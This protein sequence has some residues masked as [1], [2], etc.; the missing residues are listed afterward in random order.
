M[1]VEPVDLENIK[2]D[3]IA[4]VDNLRSLGSSNRRWL[5]VFVTTLVISSLAIGS[6]VLTDDEGFLLINAS[7]KINGSLNVTEN[8]TAGGFFLGDISKTTGGAAGGTSVWNSSSTQAFL[9]DSTMN[10]RIDGDIIVDKDI[11]DQFLAKRSNTPG[12]SFNGDDDTGMSTNSADVLELRTGGT[13][14]IA[15]RSSGIGIST[16]GTAGDPGFLGNNLG[17]GDTGFFWPAA[18]ELCFTAGAVE[19]LCFDE[20]NPSVARFNDGGVDVDHQFKSNNEDNMF[21]I[22]GGTDKIGI[23]TSTPT[24]VLVVIGDANVTGNLTFNTLHGEM[25]IDGDVTV[26]IDAS[27]V[28]FNVTINETGDLNGFRHNVSN[29]TLVASQH[30]DYFITYSASITGGANDIYDIT[31]AINLDPQIDCE[32]DQK[33]SA[34]GAELSLSASCILELDPDDELRMIVLNQGAT[35]DPTFTHASVV[36]FRI[37]I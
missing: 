11:G 14:R 17:D 18:D 37:G 13:A 23:G 3:V 36:L 20:D 25:F 8:V 19:F 29:G 32:T 6:I 26:P 9:N 1:V 33:L 5:Q 7:T 35:N 30:G 27:G 15:I 12:Y 28:F 4:D 21:F 16:T 2:T 24:D 31:M 34:G 22:D 10:L